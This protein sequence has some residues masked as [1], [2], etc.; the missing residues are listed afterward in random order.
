M[1]RDRELV[2]HVFFPRAQPDIVDDQRP[3]PGSVFPVGYDADVLHLRAQV[4][5][6]DVAG[7]KGFVGDRVA[8]TLKVTLQVEHAAVVD[9]GI[10]FF[11]P[12]SRGVRISREVFPHVFVDALLQIDP[13]GAQGAYYHVRADAPDDR[14]VT[15]RVG[16][17]GVGGVVKEGF[18]DLRASVLDET[19]RRKGKRRR[20]REKHDG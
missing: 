9:V 12:P 3:L 2:E 14:N 16:N 19:L 8:L 18:S 13:L 6:H 5:G 11:Q 17:P 7:Q 10:R 4:P 20:T 1:P 15:H